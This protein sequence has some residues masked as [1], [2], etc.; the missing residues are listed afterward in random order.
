M[1]M[2]QFFGL[3]FN[4]FLLILM[5]II[6]GI[7]VISFILYLLWKWKT[8]GKINTLPLLLI[9]VLVS[10]LGA[11]VFSILGQILKIM[12]TE[13]IN[14]TEWGVISNNSISQ[15]FFIL[16]AYYQFIFNF[17]MFPTSKQWI[18]K[19]CGAVTIGSMFFNVAMPRYL[20]GVEIEW[21]P[22]LKY[23]LCFILIFTSSIYFVISAHRIST[24]VNN[25]MILRRIL[26][27][28][29]MYLLVISAGALFGV[30][31]GAE[32]YYTLRLY[33]VYHLSYLFLII[34]LFFGLLSVRKASDDERKELVKS[35]QFL[36]SPSAN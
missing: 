35:R 30:A 13:S 4:D 29:I 28:N 24:F 20:M 32:T 5:Q 36:G 33:Y 18:V 3:E 31:W 11:L 7:L 22:I 2:M 1:V 19:T 9:S 17:E 23:I 14:Q 34:G 6:V 8:S 10:Y 26:Y 21:S 27:T 15:C 16:A 25:K 12:F